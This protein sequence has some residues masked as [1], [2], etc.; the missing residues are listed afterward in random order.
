MGIG[1][2]KLLKHLNRGPVTLCQGDAHA[3]QVL[4][5]DNGDVKLID[6]SWGLRA[7]PAIDIGG[8]MT[9]LKPEYRI[10]H[11]RELV[12]YYWEKL[13]EK[14][15]TVS[16]EMTFN[17]FWEGYELGCL[18]RG[19][20]IAALTGADTPDMKPFYHAHFRFFDDEWL[21]SLTHELSSPYPA[22]NP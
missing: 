12:S 18:F 5:L 13:T 7:H 2:G 10:E 4:M 21:A 6:Y 22:Q 9:S 15:G 16:P 3:G 1:L 14:L 11:G 20:F 8:I 19:L 17:E